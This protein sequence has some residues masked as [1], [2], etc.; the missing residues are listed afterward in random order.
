MLT[1][2]PSKV[3]ESPAVVPLGNLN[4]FSVLFLAICHLD[5]KPID[6]LLSLQALLAP[7]RVL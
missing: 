5:V 2:E 6:Q 1:P 7:I 3:E 4:V